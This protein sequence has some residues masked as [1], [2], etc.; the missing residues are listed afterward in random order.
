[1]CVSVLLTLQTSPEDENHKEDRGVGSGEEEEVVDS[2]RPRRGDATVRAS[3]NAAAVSTTME[4]VRH[5]PDSR[6]AQ[7][8]AGSSSSSNSNSSGHGGG[9]A[10]A[11]RP[12][13]FWG[14]VVDELDVASERDRRNSSPVSDVGALR[15]QLHDF[16]SVPYHLEKVARGSSLVAPPIANVPRCLGKGGGGKGCS[17]ASAETCAAQFLLV[18][19]CACVDAFLYVFTLLPIRLVVAFVLLMTGQAKRYICT[20]TYICIYMC[21]CAN[22]KMCLYVCMCICSCVWNVRSPAVT[23]L[24]VSRTRVFDCSLGIS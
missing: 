10:A 24:P 1:M 11:S 17:R 22:M 18:G 19:V 3:D 6:E 2:E 5:E 20:H 16:V 9:A 8:S 7:G 23:I 21:V 13:S 12:L 4:V 14:Y 15:E